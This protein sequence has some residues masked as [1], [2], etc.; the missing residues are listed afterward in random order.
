MFNVFKSGILIILMTLLMIFI[1]GAVGGQNGAIVFFII[2][3]VFNL[4]SY[5]FSDKIVIAM[6]RAKKADPNEF[7]ELYSILEELS[8]RAVLPVI[9]EL[10]IVPM[11]VP[12]AFATGRSPKKA[13]VAVTTGLLNSLDKDE[14][15]A[16]IAHELG[17]IKNWD[18][19]IQTIVASMASA[20]MWISYIARWG[21]ILGGGRDDRGNALGTLFVAL[22]APIAATLIQLGVSRSR[23]YMADD[24]SKKLIG[25]GEPLV[26]ALKSLHGESL[27]HRES[28][29]ISPATA[30]MFIFPSGLKGFFSLFSTHPSLEKRIANLRK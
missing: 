27:H 5:L 10:Y 20:V 28:E 4:F 8:N 24:F 21:A 6:Y 2:S 13:V 17:H 16:V 3:M 11:N 12:N 14:I 7:K 26:S 1:G 15:A 19:L 30:H 25:S 29:E 22:I 23:E 9:P 18:M